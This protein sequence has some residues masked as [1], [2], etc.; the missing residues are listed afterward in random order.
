MTVVGKTIRLAMIK[1]TLSLLAAILLVNATLRVKFSPRI[2][3]ESSTTRN[4]LWP[5]LW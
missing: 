1:H 2:F 4:Y 5:N 3:P